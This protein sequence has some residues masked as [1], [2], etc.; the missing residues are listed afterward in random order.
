[1]KKQLLTNE[2]LLLTVEEA[3]E[4]CGLSRSKFYQELDAGTFPSVQVG[5]SRRIPRGWLE[6]W[7]ADQVT[8]WEQKRS[9]A[10]RPG[11]R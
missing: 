5:R 4:L 3:A 10:A 2:K 1:M 7:V 11:G 8:A 6:Q 9:P